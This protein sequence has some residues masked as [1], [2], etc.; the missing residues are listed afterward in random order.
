MDNNQTD[1]LSKILSDPQSL[2]TISSIAKNLMSSQ[3]MQNQ[4]VVS[5]TTPQNEE[6]TDNS[7]QTQSIP[8]P[9]S[10]NS[11]NTSFEQKGAFSQFD[12]RANLLRSIKPYLK[13]ER[14]PKVDSLLKAI[15]IAKI[16]T[17]YTGNDLFS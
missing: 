5:E 14:Q 6:L 13:A 4:T 12:E 15:N 8:A 17:T 11:N 2:M 9:S 1:A 7:T 3:A 16:I 10:Q